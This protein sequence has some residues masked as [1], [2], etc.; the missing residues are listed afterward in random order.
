[1]NGPGT[2]TTAIPGPGL[3]HTLRRAY[4]NTFDTTPEPTVL[5]PSRMIAVLLF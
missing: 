5:P 4:F 2:A 3:R 1:M